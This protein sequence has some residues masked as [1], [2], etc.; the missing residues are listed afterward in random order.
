MP[1]TYTGSLEGD[2]ILNLT[3]YAN[4]KETALTETTQAA[5]EIAKLLTNEQRKKLSTKTLKWI[6]KHKAIDAKKKKR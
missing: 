1:C 2:K 3:E 5:C 4:K 6:I